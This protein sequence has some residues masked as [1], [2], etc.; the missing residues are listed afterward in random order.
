MASDSREIQPI[1]KNE[2]DIKPAKL[3]FYCKIC[4]EIVE[5]KQAKKKFH[6]VCPKCGKQDIAF[7][8]EESIRNHYRIKE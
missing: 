7:G 5:A 3:V 1:P 6:F 8:T 2:E 4:E